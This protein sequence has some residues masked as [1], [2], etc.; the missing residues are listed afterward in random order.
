MQSRSRDKK[1]NHAS[2]L[3]IPPVSQLRRTTLLT[4]SHECHISQ[5]WRAHGPTFAATSSP[6]RW[7]QLE[8]GRE[9][10]TSPTRSRIGAKSLNARR[11]RPVSLDEEPTILQLT[12]TPAFSPIR[13]QIS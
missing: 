6:V 2:D 7:A 5:P 8:M 12:V 13:R 3:T 4:P 11:G 1:R 10:N 9:R